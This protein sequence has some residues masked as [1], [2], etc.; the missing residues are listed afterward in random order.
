MC[1]CVDCPL[2]QAPSKCLLNQRT[3]SFFP[4]LHPT[5]V[6]H[7]LK[8]QNLGQV[9][10][11]SCSP[12]SSYCEDLG[13]DTLTPLPSMLGPLISSPCKGDGER[14]KPL[15]HFSDEKTEAQRA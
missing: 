9:T 8:G 10:G 7:A 6:L 5:L 14:K 13:N 11:F 12:C 1:H 4:G 2:P 3:K 15:S